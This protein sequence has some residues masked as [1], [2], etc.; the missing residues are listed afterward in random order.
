MVLAQAT[1]KAQIVSIFQ[2]AFA[3]NPHIEFL[4]GKKNLQRKIAVMTSYVVDIALKRNGLYLSEDR[5]GVLI[6]FEAAKLPLSFVEKCK[7]YA[8]VLRCFD[9]SRIFSI[10]RTE[11]QVTQLRRF[12]PGDLYVW[13]YAVSEKNLGS[14]TARNLLNDLFELAKSKN[15][16][17]V[18]ETSIERNM[19][20]YK[21]YSFDCYEQFDC[22]T[23]PI[24]YMRRGPVNQD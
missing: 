10:A 15:A 1:D 24:Y 13:F 11:G 18:A 23:F 16:G 21:R 9:L 7:Q 3:A 2:Q 19:L 5:E 8:M 20:I 6:V 4:L 17:I 12:Q 22:S 14:P